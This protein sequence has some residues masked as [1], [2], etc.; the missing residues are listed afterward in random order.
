MKKFIGMLILGGMLYSACEEDP[1]IQTDGFVTQPVVYCII[2]SN[3]TVHYIR[4]GRV[5]SGLNP[6]GETAKIRDSI[7][8]D[9]IAVTVSLKEIRTGNMTSLPV[10]RYV[11]PGKDAGYFNSDSY[12][13]FRFEKDLL[14]DVFVPGCPWI[15]LLQYLLYSEIW[16][17]VQVPGMPLA[18]CKTTLVEPPVIWSPKRAETFIYIYPENPLRVQ[19]S[20]DVWNEIDVSF[21]MNEMYADS[22]VTRSFA[23]QKNSEVHFNGK[24]YEIKIPYELIVQI[25]NQNLKVRP[26]IIRRYFGPFRID[27]LTGN[28]GYYTYIE[29][30][31][32]LNDFNYNPYDNVENGIGVL[33]GKSSFI[34]TTV[35]LDQP[36]RLKFAG[37]PGLRK[38]RIIEY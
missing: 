26:D 10:Q 19:W 15:I 37:E 24:Y 27:V 30:K 4:V 12:A 16:V 33:A 8:F 21:E 35:Y 22:T 25:L 29:F 38:Y 7:C 18:S 28:K 17:T 13:V 31:D 3:D 34:K 14:Q 23:I 20:G 5:F 36:S 2:D 11:E 1:V 32:G 6:P 9:S